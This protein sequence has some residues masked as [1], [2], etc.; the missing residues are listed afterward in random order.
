MLRWEIHGGNY[1]NGWRVTDPRYL[2]GVGNWPASHQ[3]RL[4]FETLLTGKRDTQ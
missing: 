4:R 2:R 1:F 3:E